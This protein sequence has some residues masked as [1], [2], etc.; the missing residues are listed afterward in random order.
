[1]NFSESMLID[2]ARAMKTEDKKSDVTMF[3]EVTE[4]IDSQTAAVK[5]DGSDTSAL[6]QTTVSVNK[7]DR[8]TVL[9][10]DHKAIIT[11][12]VTTPVTANDESKFIRIDPNGNFIIGTVDEHGDPRG[13]YIQS[14]GTNY[15]IKDRSGNTILE[16]TSSAV[17]VFDHDVITTATDVLTTSD[18]DDQLSSSSENPVQNKVIYNALNTSGL[19]P[20]KKAVVYDAVTTLNVGDNTVTFSLPIDFVES[21]GIS[22]A[23]AW[24][25]STWT[26]AGLTIVRDDTVLGGTGSVVVYSG[27]AQDYRLSLLL[28]YK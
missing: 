24:P 19:V 20:T 2:F 5:L 26:G 9:I 14:T 15:E 7:F 28:V 18:V 3:G 25:M 22:I 10:K 11:G 8:V 1:M 23:W 12:N 21:Y 13:F 17:K 4:I 27:T 6:C 16:V